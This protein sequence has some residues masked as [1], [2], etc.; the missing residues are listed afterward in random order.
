VSVAANLRD[1]RGLIGVSL[2]RWTIILVL[3]GVVTIEGG[4]IIFTTIG[5]QNAADGAAFEA[6]RVWEETRDLGSA[7]NAAVETLA[8]REQDQ[9][10]LVDI[11]ADNTP[12]FEVRITVR[13]RAATLIVHRIGF[14]E[15]FATVEVEA[16]ARASEGGI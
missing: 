5:L 11:D 14:L 4:S 9:A 15:D 1:E 3:L 13:K 12:P 10:R 2:I 6:A 7:S 8:D 16:E